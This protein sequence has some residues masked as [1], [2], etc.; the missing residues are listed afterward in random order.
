[1]KKKRSPVP[2]L[3]VGSQH[4]RSDHTWHNGADIEIGLYAGSL[5]RAAKVLLEKLD[6]SEDTRTLWD[7]GPIIILYREAVELQM[8]FLVEEGGR[9]L[10]PPTDHLTLA[11][12]KSL[13]WLAQIVCQILRAVQWESEF[14]CD[15]VSNLAAFSTLIKELENMEPVAAAMYSGKTKHGFGDVPPQLEKAKVREV[16]PKL[17][18]LLELLTATADGLAATAQLMELDEGDGPGEAVVH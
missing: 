11:K 15:G 2:P 12:T 13:R 6:R 18:A 14:R 17:D 4:K 10:K 1:M 8:K 3:P 5:H 16:V 7:V 9:F